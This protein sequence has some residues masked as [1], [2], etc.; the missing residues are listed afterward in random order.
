MFTEVF[1]NTVLVRYQLYFVSGCVEMERN[2]ISLK[3]ALK[4]VIKGVAFCLVFVLLFNMVSTIL[5][6]TGDYRN[7]QWIRGFY[8]EED[9]D[10]VYIGSSNTYAYWNPIVA[11]EEYGIKVYPFVCA[12]QSLYSAKYMVKEVQ[13]KHPGAVCI[14]N[15]NALREDLT[16][17]QLHYLLDY[18]PFSMNKLEMTKYLTEIAQ[19]EEPVEFYFPIV[20]YHSRWSDLSKQDF[21]YELNG[22]KGASAYSTYLQTSV[23][24]TDNYKKSDKS[25]ELS[26]TATAALIDLLEYCKEED[27]KLVFVTV[28]QAKSYLR[29]EQFNAVREMVE[30]YGFPTVS[31]L[32]DY[33]KININLEKDF[34]NKAHT[35]IHGSLKYTHYLSQYL[36]DNYGFVNNKDKDENKSWNDAEEKYSDIIAPYV[37]DFELDSENRDINLS[38]PEIITTEIEEGVVNIKWSDVSNAEGYA[39]YRKNEDGSWKRTGVTSETSYSDSDVKSGETY[40][41]TVVPYYTEASKSIYGD[42][43][44][45][46]MKV[47]V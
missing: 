5:C 12:S 35:N 41:Y 13:K 45:D 30:S 24:I 20:R 37:L 3:K 27:I 19:I 43:S 34:Y 31:L 11:W 39:I 21:N 8:E 36:I 47:D 15:T 2:R 16:D 4:K 26:E 22:L 44:Y 6:T 46:G 29:I 40:R 7:Y 25:R 17:V 1:V 42:F 33:E 28:P 23:D 14:F 10:A 38:E 32:N 9:L 18:M